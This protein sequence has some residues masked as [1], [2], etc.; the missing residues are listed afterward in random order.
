M[1]VLAPLEEFSSYVPLRV[2]V[3]T[4][5]KAAILDGTLRPGLLLSE[6]KIA[7]Q[8]SVSRTPVREALRTLGQEHL[9]TTL[10]GRK[11]I[12]SI[13]TIQD[14]EEIYDIR[15]IL[16]SEAL[17]R[18]SPEQSDVIKH[19]ENC[20]E[21]SNAILKSGNVQE[22]KQM[23]TE[24]HTI[25]ISVLNNRRLRQFVDSVYDSIARFRLYSLEKEGWAEAG[26]EEHSQIVSLLK[27]GQRE[28]AVNLL[29][30]HL[31]AAKRILTDMFCKLTERA[32]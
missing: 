1:P 22:L 6:N 4:R 13:P 30:E 8:L 3:L 29:R 18:I 17:R 10:P 24:F 14:I 9:V 11:V 21:R 19:L 20:I 32:A 26:V 25:I 12:V 16:E 7:T 5:L 27:A 23:N 31:S 28:A 2:A 15:W